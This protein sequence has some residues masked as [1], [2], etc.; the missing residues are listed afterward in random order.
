MKSPLFFGILI[1]TVFPKPCCLQQGFG[2]AKVAF[3]SVGFSAP[4]PGFCF[5][6]PTRPR[7]PGPILLEAR[8]ASKPVPL[9]VPPKPDPFLLC[10][11]KGEKKAHQGFP[12]DPLFGCATQ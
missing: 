1:K 6:R 9:G 3:A 11:K 4:N 12:L 10:E 2:F 5:A 8:A 7:T